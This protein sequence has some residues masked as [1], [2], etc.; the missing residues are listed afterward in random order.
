MEEMNKTSPPPLNGRT[1][2]KTLSVCVSSQCSAR[3]DV[4]C[5]VVE[6]A[7]CKLFQEIYVICKYK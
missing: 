5:S 6:H 1:N 7:Y 2:L 3:F 4:E